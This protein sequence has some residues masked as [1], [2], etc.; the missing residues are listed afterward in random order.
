MA[1]VIRKAVCFQK[2]LFNLRILPVSRNLRLCATCKQLANSST[3]RVQKRFWDDLSRITGAHLFKVPA[4]GLGLGFVLGGVALC[5][6][7]KN[8]GKHG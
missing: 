5:F 7:G 6:S 2:F 8:N 1:A 3:R 4:A